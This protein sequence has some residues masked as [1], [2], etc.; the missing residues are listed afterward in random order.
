MR[1]LAAAQADGWNLWGG[2]KT[3][4]FRAQAAD[5]QAAAAR[6]PFTISWGG[7]FV[8]GSDERAARAKAERLG[9]GPHVHVGGPERVADVL[10]RYA[11]AGAAWVVV[12]PVDSSD[13]ENAHLL[14]EAV[15][16]LLS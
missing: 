15:L 2:T 12:G 11:D 6:S 10:R 3:E 14:G 9:A 7:L 8:V 1:T 5:L 16:P 4:R 13:P